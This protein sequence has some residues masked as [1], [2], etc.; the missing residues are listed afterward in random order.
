MCASITLITAR[1]D[2]Q[3]LLLC[4]AGIPIPPATP[5]NIIDPLGDYVRVDTA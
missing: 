3:L 1:I 5:L 4:P 2:D